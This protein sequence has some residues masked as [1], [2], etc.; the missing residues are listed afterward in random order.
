MNAKILDLIGAEASATGSWVDD[1]LWVSSTEVIRMTCPHC[2]VEIVGL[3][4]RVYSTLAQHD[5]GHRME[6]QIMLNRMA[7]EDDK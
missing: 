3:A 4:E 1:N 6:L 5:F 7:M 2:S